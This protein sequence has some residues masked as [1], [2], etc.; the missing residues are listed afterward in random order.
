LLFQ[1]SENPDVYLVPRAQAK[2]VVEKSDTTNN[3]MLVSIATD[4]ITGIAQNKTAA[5]G[6]LNRRFLFSCYESEA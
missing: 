3:N 2:L 6:P 4:Q 1:P 5:E